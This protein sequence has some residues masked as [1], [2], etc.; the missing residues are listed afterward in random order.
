MSFALLLRPL[1]GG[2]DQVKVRM[3]WQMRNVDL[4]RRPPIAIEPGK[5]FIVRRDDH[6]LRSHVIGVIGTRECSMQVRDPCPGIH[7]HHADLL[8]GWSG[9]SIWYRIVACEVS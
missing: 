4:P 6:G 7:V 5:I 8:D 2:H 9:A 1:F 3:A